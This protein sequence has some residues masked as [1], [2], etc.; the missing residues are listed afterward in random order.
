MTTVEK[1]RIEPTAP[2]SRWAR[3]RRNRVVRALTRNTGSRLAVLFIAF[4]LVV[5]LLHVWLEPYDPNRQDLLARLEGPSSAHWLGTDQLGRDVLSRLIAGTPVTMQ[6]A[7][8][9]TTVALIGVPLGLLAGYLQGAVGALISRFSDAI[10]AIPP[11]MLA[12]AI[13]G[14]LGVGLTNA[15]IAVGIALSTRFFRVSQ[16][17]ASAIRTETYVESARAIG[18]ST[19]R[20][21]LRHVLPNAS[22]P[23]LVQTSFTVGIV[24]GVESGLSFLGLG[25]QPPQA[26]WGGMLRDAFAVASTYPFLLLPPSI[27]ITATILCFFIIGDTVRDALGR[28]AR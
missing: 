6:A 10:Q 1:S 19:S 5:S 23:I 27:L 9:G 22:G 25:V 28:A 15:M 11:V 8:I 21:V 4:L 18:C 13:V 7:A 20:I 24:I 2:A 3:F 16:T 17:A 26:S 14:F 12:F